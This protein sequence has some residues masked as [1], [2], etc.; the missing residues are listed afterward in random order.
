MLLC[1][2]NLPAL[3]GAFAGL[4]AE[5]SAN[6]REGAS[7]GGGILL[8]LDL[9]RRFALG[10][11]VA[12]YHD[13]DEVGALEPSVLARL[14]FPLKNTYPFVQANLGTV[15]FFEYGESFPA[16]LGSLS[17]GWRFHPGRSWYIEPSVRGGYPFIWGAGLSV[18]MYFNAA[19]FSFLRR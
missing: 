3:D 16:F 8:G 11:K 14:Y 18:G 1:A 5:V 10:M 9:S 12:Y 19:S 17:A 6:T 4:G 15:I 2:A 13:A 7:V